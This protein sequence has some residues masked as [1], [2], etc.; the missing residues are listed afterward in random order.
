M[1]AFGTIIRHGTIVTASE[2]VDACCLQAKARQGQRINGRV[3][4]HD[5]HARRR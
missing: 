3:T 5:R 1:V 4:V 2:T